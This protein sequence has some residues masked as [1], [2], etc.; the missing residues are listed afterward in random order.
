MLC[1]LVALVFFSALG[2]PISKRLIGQTRALP[3]SAILG[4]ATHSVLA[5]PIFFFIP[6]SAS[7]IA[8]VA[9]V[10]LLL[11]HG[12]WRIGR[13]LGARSPARRA[14]DATGI[15]G[16]PSNPASDSL[17]AL[18][19][20]RI[21]GLISP[22]AWLIAVLL[23]LS[24]AAAIAPKE[25]KDGI[26][27]SDQIFDHAKIAIIDDMARQGLP[28]GNP[29]MAHD[30]ADGRLAYYY[31]WY[32][33]AA[34]LS[35][36]LG[37]SGWEAD[38]GLTFFSVLVSLAVMMA[39]AARLSGRRM[40]AVWV[41]LVAASATWRTTLEWLFG[42]AS[43]ERW[44]PAPGGLG[45]WMFQSSWVPQ[46][47]TST[48]CVLTAVY[49]IS[50]LAE[51]PSVLGALVLGLVVA[52][53]FE[54]STWIGG[55]CF[56]FACV[57]LVPI[58][59]VQ[60]ETGRRRSLFVV[61]C[62][63][64]IVAALVSSP[65]VIDQAAAAARRQHQFP[66]ALQILETV[67]PG[68]PQGW[69]MLLDI[70]VCW[71]VLLP[72]ELSLSYLAGM[73]VII[74]SLHW[75]PLVSRSQRRLVLL[76]VALALVSLLVA[77]CLAS[78]LAFNNDLSWRAALLAVT[79][80][81]VLAA[82]GL[83]FWTAKKRWLPVALAIIAMTLSAPETVRL[84][85]ANLLASPAAGSRAFADQPAMW[86]KVRDHTAPDQRI[87]NNPYAFRDM[88]PWPVNISWALLANRRSCYAGWELSQVYTSVPH[89][90][91]YL[92]DE[93]FRRIFAGD[94]SA[95][96]LHQLATTFD[97]S[98]AVVTARDG[99]WTHDPFATSADYKLVEELANQWRIYRRST[100]LAGK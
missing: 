71:L 33:S 2:Y 95:E 97:C 26:L 45:G 49:L 16:D 73:A 22:A 38:I 63:A 57:A 31:L 48:S 25:V 17:F 59:I 34:E 23:A 58:A 44:L 83:S 80:L 13:R 15:A 66:I 6:F 67:G 36:V 11:V 42:I 1:A 7:N 35:R 62:V 19:T 10:F 77:T 90:E 47:L 9:L 100:D 76:L 4:W 51:R 86:Q 84:V 81:I 65:F 89:D 21:S 55:L 61:L 37:I 24:A 41:G 52:A 8:L 98:T 54:S 88:T 30:G 96:D 93:K 39:M 79:A 64:G 20:P 87:A 5:L 92:V 74:R 75:L 50:R 82:V 60:G 46:H 68:M 85:H 78:T 69:R 32:F 70:P 72:V 28:P 56:A 27:L 3:F 99:S 53:G 94:A 91:L 29:F 40:A 43:M 18:R 12:I 14:D